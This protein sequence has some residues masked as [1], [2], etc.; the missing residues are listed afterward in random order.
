ML[1]SGWISGGFRGSS[2]DP[3]RAG[4]KDAKS[5]WDLDPN[6]DPAV[7]L[8]PGFFYLN[9]SV[10]TLSMKIQHL[11]YTDLHQTSNEVK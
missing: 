1:G 6:Y 7:W 9:L 2:P 11:A 4:S 5:G 8:D 10:M 3:D